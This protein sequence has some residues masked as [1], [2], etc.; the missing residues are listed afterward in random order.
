MTKVGGLPF[1]G[2]VA[3][4]TGGATGIGRATARML[5]ARGAQL[6][7]ADKDGE[8]A[9][10]CA[11]ELVSNGASAFGVHAD[12]AG[13][14]SVRKLIR[15]SVSEFG[16]IDVLFSNAAATHLLPRDNDLESLDVELWDETMAV[17]LRGTMLGAKYVIPIMRDQGSGVIVNVASST[18]L[19]GGMTH[20]AYGTSKSAIMAFTKYVATMYGRF[21]VRCNAVA[22]GLIVTEA[23]ASRNPEA[24]AAYRRHSLVARDGVMDDIASLVCF[25]C[26]D[27][28][29]FITG[30]TIVADGGMTSHRPDYID[31]IERRA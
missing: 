1:E 23:M 30:E 24:P 21:G 4:V 13:E 25:L 6:V 26:S 7:V 18:A 22:P 29:G 15:T 20:L 9:S 10:A 27:E 12:V 8:G 28:A 5:S 17:N 31:Y 11:A 2:R 16:R 14:A 19:L 3:I